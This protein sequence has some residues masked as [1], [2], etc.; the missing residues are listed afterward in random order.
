MS[1]LIGTGPNQ[2]PTNA[3]LGSIAYQ[4][5]DSLNVGGVLAE[6]ISIDTG[7]QDTLNSPYL[8]TVADEA[9]GI[10]ID[11]VSSFPSKPGGIFSTSGASG[12]FPFDDYGNIIITT[13]TDY[14]GYY[15]IAMVTA[16]TN[17]TPEVRLVV[18][19]NGN[20]GIGT[21]IPSGDLDVHGDT[22]R[23]Y[24]S[25]NNNNT[26]LIAENTGVGNAGLQMKNQDGTWTFIANDRLRIVD[27]DAGL[28]RLSITSNGKVGIGN[29]SPTSLLTLDGQDTNIDASIRLGTAGSRSWLLNAK[30]YDSGASYYDLWI[31]RDM[32]TFGGALQ[33]RDSPF[34]VNYTNQGPLLKVGSSLTSTAFVVATEPS[35]ILS[36][37]DAGNFFYFTPDEQS[38]LTWDFTS[39]YDIRWHARAGYGTS[40]Y[41]RLGTGSDT[42]I[43]PV[44]WNG[45]VSGLAYAGSSNFATSVLLQTKPLSSSSWTTQDST[46]AQSSS[47]GEYLIEWEPGTKLTEPYAVRFRFNQSSGVGTRSDTCRLRN[48]VVTDLQNDMAFSNINQSMTQYNGNIAI[49]N[50]TNVKPLEKFE[51]HGENGKL[52]SVSDDISGDIF[53]VSGISGVPA[54]RTDSYGD[55]YN[56]QNSAGFSQFGPSYITRLAS[57]YRYYDYST[58]P[59]TV[60]RLHT[61]GGHGAA[62]LTATLID[63]AYR[64]GSM[65]QKIYIAWVGSGSA[66]SNSNLLVENKARA[67]S[68]TW[69]DYL[70][71]TVVNHGFK[72]I[73]IA[74]TAS[75]TTGDNGIL[76]LHGFGSFADSTASPSIEAL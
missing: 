22:I 11:Y 24:N 47:T 49:D 55:T 16:G 75:T 4:D 12:T 51:V 48:I 36:E 40:G 21:D 45:K 35:P 71:W 53:A 2:V 46:S 19:S 60:F 31:E 17:N 67:N 26:F 58:S 73:D 59:T 43:L 74:V 13:R 69:P 62:E 29:T 30:S 61:T 41:L 32:D 25:D 3:N 28:E 37:K 68:G 14:G 8:L 65:I 18:K 63:G 57:N 5:A 33:L 39:S 15:D 23:L 70:T 34:Y 44:G 1:K 9:H 20:V 76:H 52:F 50:G 56:Q 10:G 64:N 6:K 54:M 38:Y 72:I 27:G 66:V 7:G 42:H